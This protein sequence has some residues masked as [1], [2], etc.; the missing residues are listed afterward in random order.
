LAFTSSICSSRFI[1][2][3]PRC[4]ASSV[5]VKPANAVDQ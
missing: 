3:Y 2:S 4:S 1:S 5:G